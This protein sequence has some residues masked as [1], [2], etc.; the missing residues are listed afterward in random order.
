MMTE[1]EFCWSKKIIQVQNVTGAREHIR[2]QLDII[3][4]WAKPSEFI[5]AIKTTAGHTL[6]TD[7]DID[8]ARQ[9]HQR[10]ATF[11]LCKQA[12]TDQSKQIHWLN[13]GLYLI[14][15]REHIRIAEVIC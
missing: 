13:S 6:V 10:A 12:A 7:A 11:R 2:Q 1:L 8:I 15:Y 5:D 3:S 9:N 4:E 14:D